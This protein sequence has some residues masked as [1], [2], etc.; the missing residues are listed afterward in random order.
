MPIQMPV[1]Q[2]FQF[3]PQFQAIN[4]N[5]QFGSMDQFNQTFNQKMPMQYMPNVR[6]FSDI[7]F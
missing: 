4:M 5:N 6:L 1:I 7:I 2:P 3:A